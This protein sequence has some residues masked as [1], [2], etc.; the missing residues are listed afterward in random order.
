[1]LK[2]DKETLD[3]MESGYPGIMKNILYFEEA[4]LPPCPCCTSENTA[5][6]QCGIIGRTIN[7]VTATTKFRLIP[8]GPVPGKYFCNKCGHYFD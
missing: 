2:V 8:N 3:H 4:I 6:V 1:M 5:I 7:I